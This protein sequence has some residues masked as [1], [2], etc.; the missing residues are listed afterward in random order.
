[1]SVT[2]FTGEQRDFAVAVRDFSR[3]ECGTREQ[4]DALTD[5]GT[6]QHHDGLFQKLASSGYLGVSIPE[7][8]GGSGGGLTEQVILF[9]EL[10]RGLV[11]V[12]G[13]GSSH[14]VAGIY[15]RFAT[16][17]QKRSALGAICSGTVMS[18]SISEPGAGSDAAAIS[19][20]AEKVEEGF[21]L[22]G[23]KTWCSDAQFATTILVLARTGR[24]D[25]P[26][27]GLTMFELPADAPGLE[28]RPISTLGGSEVNDLF[29]T[30]V[31][32]PESAIVG[33]EGAG[34]KQ[35]MAGLNGERLVCAAQ[36]LGMAQRTFDD[37]LEYVTQ[38]EQFGS[39]I[40]SFQA[41]RH[42]IADLAIEIESARALTYA[43][44]HMVEQ[45]LG[46]PE[47][48][49]RMTSMAK[50]KVTETAKKVALEGVQMMGG[51][52]YSTEFDM[53]RHLRLSIAPTIYAGTNEIQRD[54]ISG[55]FGLRP[56]R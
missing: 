28:I 2:G 42:R 26:H 56:V 22:N 25:K 7:E 35:V 9:E 13:A 48:R 45:E 34:W 51:Y 17:D 11:P 38:R 30:D 18:I 15:K 46:S 43:T 14:T 41:L 54:I 24:G 27:A 6:E 23:Q 33:E 53:E 36:G 3:K 12:H 44:V 29:L 19:C 49:V 21:R 55:T 50:V 4:R 1:M 40:G 32:L 10:W 47:E 5:H 52:G 39:P 20:R 16:E 37:L 8:Y 31:L